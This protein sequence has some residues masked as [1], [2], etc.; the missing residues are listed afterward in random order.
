MIRQ[1]LIRHLIAHGCRLLREGR[2][3]SVW[4]NPAS[5]RQAAVPRHREINNYTARTI[6][7]QLGIPEP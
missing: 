1:A 4:F 6:C 5:Q 3:H 2:L 7:R